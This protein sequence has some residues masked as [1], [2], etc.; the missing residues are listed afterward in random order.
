[1]SMLMPALF[2]L[3]IGMALVWSLAELVH[4]NADKM[5]AALEGDSFASRGVQDQVVVN[6][7]WKS[8]GCTVNRA[9]PMFLR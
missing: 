5:R 7:R 9:S 3:A 4:A 6:V 1:M 2:V 8:R